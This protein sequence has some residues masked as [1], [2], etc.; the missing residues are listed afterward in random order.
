MTAPVK[1]IGVDVD[2]TLGAYWTAFRAWRHRVHNVPL[3][4]MP[5]PAR[6]SLAESG[7]GFAHDGEYFD[8]HCQA[9]EDGLL[10]D[11]PPL[12]G[13]RE[14]L[15]DLRE[16]GVQIVIVTHRLCADRLSPGQVLADTA[17]WLEEHDLAFDQI[18][19]LDDKSRLNLD[20]FFDD[21]PHNI[22]ALRAAGR[23]AVCMDAP[24]NA[25]LPGPRA[26]SWDECH[27]LAL[28]A[29]ELDA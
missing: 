17:A 27:R 2:D 6:W 22:A 10:R 15:R 28:K 12:P 29:L 9:V 21:A 4:Q 11:L 14:A 20:L 5:A 13:A 3:E 7:W 18:C 8:A 25:G 16:R 26:R 24:Y 1:A 19:F 23:R